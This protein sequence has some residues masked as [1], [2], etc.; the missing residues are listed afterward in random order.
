MIGQAGP[1]TEPTAEDCRPTAERH[2]VTSSPRYRAVNS[3]LIDVESAPSVHGLQLD[4]RR[5]EKSEMQK[6]RVTMEREETERKSEEKEQ[7]DETKE[8]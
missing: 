5:Q 1:H 2:L 7:N 8:R 3:T 6:E 4:S